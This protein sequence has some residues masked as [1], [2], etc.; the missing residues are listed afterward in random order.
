MNNSP[1]KELSF[2]TRGI[3]GMMKDKDSTFVKL[4][5]WSAV[6]WTSDMTVPVASRI[7]LHHTSKSTIQSNREKD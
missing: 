7:F 2:T 6:T 4:S 3:L 5:N 1:N